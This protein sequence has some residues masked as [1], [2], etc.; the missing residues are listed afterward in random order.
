MLG[1]GVD[2]MSSLDFSRTC[3]L[4]PCSLCLLL[5]LLVVSWQSLSLLLS[6]L[7]IYSLRRIYCNPPACNHQSSE[8]GA[9]AR[10]PGEGQMAELGVHQGV[11][12]GLALGV[13][14][15]LRDRSR[16][17]WGGFQPGQLA[18]SLISRCI[19]LGQGMCS[20]SGLFSDCEREGPRSMGLR[21]SLDWKSG[22]ASTGRFPAYGLC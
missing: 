22:N 7:V 18:G 12:D 16:G 3:D 13:G 4:F 21:K 5:S 1:F 10:V 17:W 11:P 14:L 19:H 6:Y 9:W 20:L 15:W 8:D 2:S